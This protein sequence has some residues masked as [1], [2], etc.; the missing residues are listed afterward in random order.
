V[1]TSRFGFYEFRQKKVDGKS[2]VKSY[3]MCLKFLFLTFIA[4]KYTQ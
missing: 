4:L 2:I 3:K 1:A